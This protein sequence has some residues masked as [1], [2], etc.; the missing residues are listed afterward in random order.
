M[1]EEDD[2]LLRPSRPEIVSARKAAERAAEAALEEKKPTFGEAVQASVEEDWMMSWALRG[3]EEF[4]PDP[5]FQLSTEDYNR[6]TSGLPEDYH[7]FVEDSVSMAHLESLREEA[8]R[9]YE[10]DQKLAQLG[11]GGVGIR[12][13]V[14]LADPAAIGIS[15]ATEGVAAPL[16]W[17]NKLTRLQRAF[18]GGAAAATTN[19]IVESYI[20]SQN[21][22]K[23]P[24]DIL[25][26]ASAGFLIGGGLSTFGRVDTA[27]PIR[28]AMANMAKAADDAQQVE[29]VDAV[30]SRI[31]GEGLG[32]PF[33]R[34]VEITDD[35][36]NAAL[37][38][39]DQAREAVSEARKAKDAAAAQIDERLEAGEIS[40][41]EASRLEA[42]LPEFRVFQEAQKAFNEADKAADE[43]VARQAAGGR[44]GVGAAENQFEPPQM[45]GYTRTDTE[46][47]IEAAGDP[48]EPAMAKLGPT[49]IPLRFDMIARLLGSK[50]R[51]ANQLGRILG[52]DAVGFRGGKDT[53]RPLEAT[54]DIIKTNEFKSALSRYYAVYDPAYKEW[55]KD[56]GFGYFKRTMNLPRRQFGELVADAIENPELPFHPAVRRAAQRQAEI[57]RDLLNGAKDSEVRGF[58]SVPENLRYFTHL[59][60][61]FKFVEARH[62]YGDVAVSRLL[63]NALMNGTEDMN[64]EAAQ[65]IVKG[66][67]GKL[68][69]DGAGMDSGA[70]RLFTTEDRD[71]MKQILV[72]EGFMT[73][74]EA[75]RLMSLFEQR[76]DGTP[77]RARR[78]LGFNMQEELSVFNS[79]TRQ[80]ETLRLKDLQER[81]AEQVFTSYAGGMSGRIA[82]ARVGLKDETTI[83]Q[84]LDRNLSEAEGRAG[85][86]GVDEAKHENLI[87]Q[88]MINMILNRRAP[89]A[90]DP[91]GN[92]AR[93]A[94]LVQDYNFIRLMNQVGF[95]QVAELGN[96]V[97]IGGWRAVLQQMPEMRRVL[98][99]AKNGELE[100]EVLRDIEAAT[101]IGSDR[102]TNQ[103]MNRAGTIGV[104]SEGR[105]DWIDKA[106]F[107]LAPLKRATADLSGMAPITLALER[108]A[109]RVAVQTMTDLAFKARNLSRKRLAGLGLDEAM[110]ERVYEQIRK[111]AVRQPSSMFK[112]KKVRAINLGAW[113]DGEARDA[114]LIAISRWTRRSIQQNDVGNLNLYMTSTMGQI[115]TQFRTFMLVS[116]AKQTLHNIKANDFRGYSGMVYSAAFAGLSYVAQTQVNA[117]FRDDKEEFLKE[118]LSA[119]A[120]GRAAFQRS[121]WAS[122][123]PALVDTGAMFYS[124]D[125]V[126]A[127]RSTG[128]DTNLIGGVPSVQ[129]ISKGLS[130]AQAASRALLN[131]DKQ[132]SQGQQRA[133][134]TLVPFQN[135]IGIKNAL[136]KLVDMRPETATVE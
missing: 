8:L 24:Y 127:Y 40:S 38:R 57:K 18:R 2:I 131:P 115:L 92:Y 89:L 78:R 11:W 66:M 128:L 72:E 37:D 44:T 112:R 56:Q 103:A 48:V 33:G 91:S 51:I 7:G 3:R 39:A 119:E 106:L 76:P 114:F 111:N 13:G 32:E 4:A 100:D 9:T 110:A 55:A 15:I 74:D 53:E 70:A 64:E 23:D 83:N 25:Y 105:G 54:A 62:R 75:T 104:F 50:N 59:W 130:S 99:R 12:F 113:D 101:G 87:A 84:L 117:Q 80:Q 58:E 30:N 77:Q 96:A 19:A 46:N 36:V 31:L 125:P 61:S 6:I 68:N 49:G 14:A 94:R 129:L 45:V 118:R 107:M 43:A 109:V 122:L 42:A 71:V 121:S 102:L 136:N 29:A 124:D 73:E 34:S 82:L 79:E 26:S 88:T 123:F 90:A 63:T 27:D 28:P 134:N 17:G 93:I 85:K 108:I 116:Y 86:K 126:F 98:R 69:R 21:A 135:A 60:D 10:N 1:E 97:S 52:E 133:L 65:M 95:A 120:V 132:F 47:A 5:D 35:E 20:V 41:E 81:D 67:V 16:I 22:V